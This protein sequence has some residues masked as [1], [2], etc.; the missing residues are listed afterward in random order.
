MNWRA[1]KEF[2]KLERKK[3]D[4]YDAILIF[5]PPGAGKG[6]HGKKLG[7]LEK[8][9]YFSTGDMFRNVDTS[10]EIGAIVK[11]YMDKGELVP[12]G[13]TLKLFDIT[14][15]RDVYDGRYNPQTQ[16]LLLEGI[17]RNVEQVPPINQRGNVSQIVYLD[18]PD[19]VLIERIR[20]R[21]IEEKRP[22]DQDP[23]I[24]QNRLNVY[25]EK[26]LPVLREYDSTLVLKIDASGGVDE[27]YQSILE[28]LIR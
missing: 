17:P 7:E 6:T 14:I 8:Y 2:L 24:I 10:T 4:K 3:T 25:R 18:A 11:Y 27:V 12:D 9:F 26:T 22:D 23:K 28:K 13:L 21:A 15:Q 5:G 16:F 20:Q 19:D 1:I